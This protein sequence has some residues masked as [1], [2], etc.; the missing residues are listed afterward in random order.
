MK[1]IFYMERQILHV[2]VN[3]AFLSWTAV[4]L[5]KNGYET[6]LR[7]IPSAIAGDEQRRSGI[8]LAKSI[9]A[10][11]CGINTA[12]TIYS[13]KKKCPNLQIFPGLDY[14]KYREYSDNLFKLLS[15]YTNIIER[16]S[17][18]ECFLDITHFLMG[19]DSLNIALEINKRI[20]NELGFTVNIGV[21]HNKLLAKMASDFT[22]PNKVHTLFEDEIPTKMWP[23][24]ISELFMLGKRTAPKLY[25]MQIRT[26]GD[27]AKIDKN[28]L[29]KKFGKHGALM[30]EYAN[31]I[32]NSE[33]HFQKEDPKSIGNS[34]TLP[35][36]AFNIE[37]IQEVLLTLVEQVTYRLRKSGQL[38]NVVSVQL[39]TKNF[40]D[41]SH[42]QKLDFATA[43]T[44]D[45]YI[46]S[47][48][49]LYDMF[50]NGMAIRLVGVRVDK[51]ISKNEMQISFFQNQ[52]NEKQ[53]KLDKTLDGLKQKFGYNK[54]TRAG[55]LNAEKIIDTTKNQ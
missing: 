52:N 35:T 7:K 50:K 36:D 9:L 8:I 17:I 55:N 25:N 29:I 39:R 40:E 37:E 20:Y 45:I 34:I 43:N 27:L 14:K 54:I 5:L 11:K 48:K 26:I 22:K 30:H 33:V 41:F 42:Q 28:V 46:L 49:L 44:K 13:A 4:E 16:Y 19:M 23:L 32:D 18:D 51:L 24:P 12:E 10:K 47:K 3:N 31:G 21:A 2:D 15:E 38:A 53:E 6:D 1:G